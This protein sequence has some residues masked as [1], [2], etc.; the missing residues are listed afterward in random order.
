MIKKQS[1][2]SY[3]YPGLRLNPIDKIGI[4]QITKHIKYNISTEEILS[5]ISEECKV[6]VEGILSRSRKKELVF[7]R[8]IFCSILK[9]YFCYSLKTIGNIIG[10]DHTTVINAIDVFRE[11]YILEL[12]YREVADKVYERVG[13]RTL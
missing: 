8:F 11:R 1:V 5:I 10:R 9:R 7:G 4:K 13:I 12:N 2:S 3:I 6:D